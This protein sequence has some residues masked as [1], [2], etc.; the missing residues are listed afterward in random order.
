MFRYEMIVVTHL[1]VSHTHIYVMPAVD[2]K[3]GVGMGELNLNIISPLCWKAS[4]GCVELLGC[5][6]LGRGF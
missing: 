2:P 1:H 5:A 6:G 4:C 3:Q